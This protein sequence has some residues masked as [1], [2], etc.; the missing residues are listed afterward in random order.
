MATTLPCDPEKDACILEGHFL[1]QRPIALPGTV[2]IDPGYPFGSTEAGTRDPHH[3]VEFYNASGTPVLAAADGQVVMAGSDR[4]IQ[5]GPRLDFYGNVV[6]LEHSFSGITQPVYTLYGHLLKV[7]VQPGQEVRSGQE[8]GLVG[9]TGEAI[10]SH[11]HFEVRLGQ[12][13]Y[14]SDRNPVLWLKFLAGPDTVSFGA[15]TGRVE[16]STGKNLHATNI[17]IQYFPDP[18]GPQAAAYQVDTY[19]P[20][21]PPVQ[22]DPLLNENFTLGDLPDG[23]Y[24]VSIILGG[25]LY[26]RWLDVLPGKLTFLVFQ[27]GQ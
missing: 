4:Q 21:Q 2:T 8:I 25:R 1:L 13:D 5:T 12:N 20:D 27:P 24:R 22:A 7:E 9:S 26:E 10:G 14:A 18:K 17:N 16:D 19:A 6:V 23:H 15:I 3:G 11:L